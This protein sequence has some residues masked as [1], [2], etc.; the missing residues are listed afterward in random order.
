MSQ[1]ALSTYL[2]EMNPTKKKFTLDDIVFNF[3]ADDAGGA[4]LTKAYKENR[5][6]KCLTE[7]DTTRRAFLVRYS[8]TNPL[9]FAI[10]RGK[11]Q[12]NTF[13]HITQRIRYKD[14]KMIDYI[15]GD[16]PIFDN[17]S[18]KLA[19]LG[20]IETQLRSLV[21]TDE[22]KDESDIDFM[23]SWSETKAHIIEKALLTY[24]PPSMKFATAV[25]NYIEQQSYKSSVEIRECWITPISENQKQTASVMNNY[26]VSS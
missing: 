25:H 7:G 9:V 15:I 24:M 12:G 5:L 8:R 11:S 1:D 23:S 2:K 13:V 19:L 22:H 18:E 14:D 21:D 16:D 17:A 3:D 20:L 26:V 6:K 10:T 4:L